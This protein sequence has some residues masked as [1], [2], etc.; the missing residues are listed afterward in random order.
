MN[1][2]VKASVLAAFIADALS[3]G[4]HWIYDTAVIKNDIG[5]IRSYHDP[6]APFHKGK[7]AGEFTHYGDQMLVLLQ[8]LK[9]KNGYHAG[10][11]SDTWRTFFGAYTGYFDHATKDTLKN[12]EHGLGPEEC[13]SESED[14]GG[15]SRIPALVS[16]YGNDMENLVS[17]ARS[18]TA[19][20]HQDPRVVE[21]AGFFA[22]LVFH[23]LNGDKP[24]VVI[25]HVMEGDLK[26]SAIAD[27]V[28]KGLDTKGLDTRNTIGK[29]GQTCSVGAALPATVHLIVSYENDLKAALAE[30]V[31][32]GGDSAA[33]GMLVGMVLGAW[34]GMDAIPEEWIVGLAVRDQI[35]SLLSG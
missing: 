1:K 29:F 30:N 18:Q 28:Q 31:M 15:A 14:L 19:I 8:S 22:R 10:S 24:S 21:S 9:N 2:R 3:L 17:S 13:G 34:N 26:G 20:T 25:P 7:T 5:A 16:M 32:A 27:M 11:F 23:T 35:L 6:I 33:R 4:A 12:L